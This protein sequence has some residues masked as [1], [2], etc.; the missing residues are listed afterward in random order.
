MERR[1][2]T[3]RRRRQRFLTPIVI[4]TLITANDGGDGD[5]VEISV[6]YLIPTHTSLLD[7]SHIQYCMY[8]EVDCKYGLCF[9]PRKY[10]IFI[11]NIY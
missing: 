10:S 3:G 2:P 6:L 1:W 8:L 5:V 11:P 9:F 7:L 4:Y